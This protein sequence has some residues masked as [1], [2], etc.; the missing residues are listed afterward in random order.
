MLLVLQN[1]EIHKD[2]QFQGSFSMLFKASNL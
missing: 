1:E 2:E